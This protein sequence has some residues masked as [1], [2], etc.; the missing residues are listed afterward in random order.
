MIQ[1]ILVGVLLAGSVLMAD[2]VPSHESM[3][4]TKKSETIHWNNNYKEALARAKK[5]D[6]PFMFIIS[7]HTCRYCVQLEETALSDAEVIDTLNKKFVTYTAYT[8]DG[9]SFPQDLW[10]GG[11]P[12]I[13]FLLPSGEPMFQPIPGAIPTKNF[14]EALTVVLKKYSQLKKPNTDKKE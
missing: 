9:D 11:T 13:W 2:G 6:K 12:M 3:A 1:K 14:K 8:D 4:V 10:N 5:E 7:R